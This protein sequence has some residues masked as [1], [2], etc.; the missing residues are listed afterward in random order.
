MIQILLVACICPEVPVEMLQLKRF[1]RLNET[2][3]RLY[4]EEDIPRKIKEL[5]KQEQDMKVIPQWKVKAG[6]NRIISALHSGLVRQFCGAPFIIVYSVYIFR[7]MKTS[8]GYTDLATLIIN[9]VQVAAGFIGLWLVERIKRSKLVF[10]STI[11]SAIFCFL[12]AVGDGI[13]SPALSL[14]AMVIFMM[15][16][17]S[18]MQSVTWFYPF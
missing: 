3:H 7:N 9:S 8:S 13:Q 12:I 17:A 15:P 16:N 1:D 2:L 11:F 18:C 5:E 6:R 14:T 10:F 4:N